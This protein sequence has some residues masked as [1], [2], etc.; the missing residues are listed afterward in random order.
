LKSREQ[1]R[2]YRLFFNQQAT[3]HTIKGPQPF[4]N[5]LST[6]TPT[7]IVGK[8]VSYPENGDWLFFVQNLTGHGIHGLQAT[9]NTL[10]TYPP[11]EIVRNLCTAPLF[12]GKPFKG[13]ISK[14]FDRSTVDNYSNWLFFNQKPG[15]LDPYS[16]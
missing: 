15:S 14:G 4:T 6:V 2:S 8:W 1:A 12:C 7:V 16:A 10:S 3:P 13:P 11:T 9:A 5:I